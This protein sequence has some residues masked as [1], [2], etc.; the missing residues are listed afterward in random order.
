MK[1]TLPLLMLLFAALAGRAQTHFYLDQIVVQPANPTTADDVTIDLVGNLSDTGAEVQ[2]LGVGIAGTQVDITLV[3]TSMGGLTVLVPHTEPIGLG[4][5]PAGTY[6][7]NFTD[8][9]TG[10]LDGAPEAQHTFTVSGPEFPCEELNVAVQ[11]APFSDT[12]VVVHVQHTTVEQ[13]DYPNFI[14]FD[15]EGDTLAKENVTYFAI[16]Q[17]SWHTLRLM[18]GVEPPVGAFDGRLE[19][20]TG[21]TSVLACTWEQ[22]F[23]LCP[24]VGCHTIYPTL[25]NF[26]G[27]I[28]IGTFN[29]TLSDDG[30]EVASGQFELTTEVQQ[31]ADTVCLPAGTY[32]MNVSPLTPPTGGAPTFYVAGPGLTATESRPVVWSLPVELEF[33]L[34]PYC[35]ESPEGT[36]ERDGTGLLTSTVPGGLW[37]RTVDGRP[38]GAVRLMDAQGRLMLATTASTDNHY[39][40]VSTPG[41][42]VLR[43]GDRTVKVA[44]GLE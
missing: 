7:I 30:G 10:L 23:H 26:G 33:P 42:Y 5:L 21:F 16:A 40:P 34:Y 11:W 37:V 43:A 44:A 18:D 19:L 20:W 12:A 3:A 13:F 17:D 32:F 36:M 28:P 25:A 24:P 31:D 27:A 15:A 38:L 41:V 22:N 4:Q 14:L 1:R 6:T 35:L 39:L 9:T 29:W 2:V 8:A